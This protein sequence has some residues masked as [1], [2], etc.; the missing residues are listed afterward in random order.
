VAPGLNSRGRVA[1]PPSIPAKPGS[2]LRPR[3]ETVGAPTRRT[4]RAR[5]DGAPTRDARRGGA[6]GR[7]V[8]ALALVALIAGAQAESRPRYGRAVVGSALGEP[9]SLDPVAARSVAETT[10]VGLVFDTLYRFGPDGR[11]A[12]H[13]ATAMPEIVDGKARVVIRPGAHFHNGAALGAAD[14]AASLA[15]VKASATAGWLLAAVDDIAVDGDAVVL[16]TTRK[17][18][19][20]ILAAPATAITPK[21]APPRAGQPIGSGPFRVA[22]VAKDRIELEAY[23]EHHGGRPYLDRVT[24]RWFTSADGEA[25]LYET[26]GADWSVHGATVFASGAPKHPTVQLDGPA[27]ILVYLGF[28]KTHAAITDNRDFRIALDLAIARGGLDGIGAGER[29]VP[30]RDPVPVELG[31]PELTAAAAAAQLPDAQVALA[32][33]AAAVPAL[34][35]AQLG[36][37]T[38]EILVDASRPDDR[39]VAERVVNALDKLGLVA[40]IAAVPAPELARRIDAGACDLYVGQ[41]A[42]AVTTP[43]LLFAAAYAAG[44]ERAVADKL[45]AGGTIDP[46]RVRAAF[47][48]RLPIVPL[49][50]RGVR[51]HVRKD[52]RG[53]WF[54]A[55]ARLAIADLFRWDR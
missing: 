30:T 20:A 25:R 43:A 49:L 23:A 55:G 1:A 13:L 48:K 46:T 45:A 21:G 6:T 9:G 26:G 2:R 35:P 4:V 40:T 37:T 42:A 17:N 33:A 5:P 44:G 3:R 27:T 32:A 19:A 36:K 18:L 53:A 41:L 29:T 10:V 14:V 38:L 31:G 8:A 15:R 24:L 54:D 50:D 52:L 47:G 51:L 34:A 22:R 39:E 28:G 16:G 7:R 12:P 11:I